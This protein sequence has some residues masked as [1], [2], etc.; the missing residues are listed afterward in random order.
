MYI[1]NY[2]FSISDIIKSCVLSSTDHVKMVISVNLMI[3]AM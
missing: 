2:V 3:T 1:C